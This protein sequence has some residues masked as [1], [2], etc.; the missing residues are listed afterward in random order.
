MST[1]RRSGFH[2]SSSNILIIDLVGIPGIKQSDIGIEELLPFILFRVFFQEFFIV[3]D[4]FFQSD[5]PGILIE[6][7][8]HPADKI[9]SCIFFCFLLGV[10]FM[11]G[12]NRYGRHLIF[13]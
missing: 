7:D 13:S 8:D 3:A 11:V 5:E 2:E 4:H 6:S 12:F 9:R 1:S 10:P